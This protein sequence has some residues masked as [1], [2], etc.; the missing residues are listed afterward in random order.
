MCMVPME[1]G[2]SGEVDDRDSLDQR[3]RSQRTKRKETLQTVG[4]IMQYI[5]RMNHW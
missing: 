1:K 2:S 3:H 5:Y 4:V